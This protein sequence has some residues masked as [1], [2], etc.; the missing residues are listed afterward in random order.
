M[1][2]LPSTRSVLSPVLVGDSPNLSNPIL[3]V[4]RPGPAG[5]RPSLS[6]VLTADRAQ[7]QGPS[8]S[9]EPVVDLNMRQVIITLYMSAH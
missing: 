4:D 3:A 6:P 5:D 9:P 1:P 7:R 2:E 8:R